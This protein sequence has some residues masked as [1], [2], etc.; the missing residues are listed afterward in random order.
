[1]TSGPD[2]DTQ[3]SWLPGDAE[4]AFLS[5]RGGAPAL[6]ACRLDGSGARAL[7]SLDATVDSVRVAP[8]GR[9][10]AY[11]A[12]E[13]DGSVDVWLVDLVNGERRRLTDDPE[14][15]GFPCWSPDGLWLAAEQKRDD[16]DRVVLID[17]EGDDGEVRVLTPEHGRFWPWSFS[18]EGRRIAFVGLRDGYWNVWWVD[19]ETGEQRQLTTFGRR[20]AY[21]RYPAWSPAGDRVVFELAE[22]L[23]DLWRVSGL[24]G[25][26]L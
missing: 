20:D 25:A 1:V 4:L 16:D 13:A 21:L 3:A 7:A 14:L 24:P 17:L 23:G 26:R 15:V 2:R 11:H 6:W 5:D 9:R 22:V 18:P 12:T 19:R 8:D 10:A